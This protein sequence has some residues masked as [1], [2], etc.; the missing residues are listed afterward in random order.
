MAF[1]GPLRWLLAHELQAERR[2]DCDPADAAPIEPAAR[3]IDAPRMLRVLIASRGV[4]P[5]GPGAGGTELVTFQLASALV[6]RGHRVTLIADFAGARVAIPAPLEVI[7]VGM[8]G[9][10]GLLRKLPRD[11]STGCSSISPAISR[12]PA[13]SARWCGGARGA[14]T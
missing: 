11:S 5:I 14:S 13:A 9:V 1:A 6:A 2:N 12:S 4:V 3:S 10:R 8:D 7:P